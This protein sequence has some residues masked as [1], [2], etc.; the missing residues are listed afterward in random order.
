MAASA[1]PVPT[2]A[3]PSAQAASLPPGTASPATGP[4]LLDLLRASM[5]RFAHRPA[6]LI[7]PGFRTRT[8]THA[9]LA[10]LMPKVARVLHEM[11]L[12]KGD[13][14]VIWAVNRPE[15]GL[16]FLGALHAGI[17]LVPLDVRS[18][19]DFAAKIARRTRASAVLASV[20]TAG[21][22]QGLHLP[23][24]N[25]EAIPDLARDAEPLP[26][27]EVT[28]AD[29]VE[30][31][32]TSGTTGEPKGAMI[33][34]ANLAAN[35][36][37][38]GTVFPFQKDER[39]LSILPLSH[40]FEQTCGFL[41]PLLYGCSIV[42]PVS[43]QPAVLI[44]T[45]RDFRVTMLLVVPAG[46]KL[47]NNAI[48]RKVDAAGKRR[49]FERLHDLGARLPRPLK[50]L[51]FRSV[52]SQFGGR[53]RTLA[54]GAAA[55]E[56]DLARRWID[57]GFDVLQGYGATELSPVVAF[58]H[59]QRNRLGTVGQA[60]PGVELRIGPDGEVLARGP[61]VFA[62]YWED[63]DATAQ[64]ID[65]DG[66]YHT[67]DIGEL[68]GDGFLTLRGRKKD[69]LAMA[70]GT[71]VYP[72]DIEAV[73]ARDPRLRDATVVG[74][75]PPNA[76]LK[77]HAVLLLDDTSLADAVIRD[78][79]AQLG[80]HQQIRSHSL[81]PDDDFPRTHTLKVKKRD[82]LQRLETDAA[83]VAAAPIARSSAAAAPGA[84]S[85]GDALA[86]LVASVAGVPLADVQPSA[87][88]SRDLNMDSLSRVELLGV[89]EEEL[90]VYID[91]A[92]L[93]PDT[94]IG[95]LAAMAEQ[96]RDAKPERGI[97][98]WPLSPVAR[99]IG[100]G[101]QAL[102]MVPFF[103][104]A[105]RVRV[106]GREH[107]RGLRGPVLFTPNHH[108][109][110][111]VGI[112]LSHFPLG[113]RWRLST[114]AAADDIFGNP[115]RGYGAAL[116]GNAFPLAR[117]GAIRRSLELLGARLDRG[118]SILIFPEGKLTP[119]GPMQ[120]FKSG[121]G[122]IAVE[123]ATPVVPMKLKVERYSRLD[124]DIAAPDGQRA[125]RGQVEIVFG[126]PIHFPWGTDHDAATR[127]LEEAVAA[128]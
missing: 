121:T 108:L 110:N 40:L 105:Y 34:H 109:H 20:Q 65:G 12:R 39:L 87:C 9:D 99:A 120:P 122:L 60:I 15:W 81:W 5:A 18:Q 123:G 24:L 6:L 37:T 28:P 1:P 67:G 116:I 45:F 98:G 83:G 44:R 111:D 106:T 85:A 29:L 126:P 47:L 118:F 86:A 31:V 68:S 26:R 43:R 58:T 94:T 112:L 50:R 115:I 77:V 90:G 74:W 49:T 33:T 71:K 46:L 51:L 104:L 11:G 42:Y 76:E 59:P 103:T 84:A 10:Q 96:A 119:G 69:M 78:A 92:D 55:L 117:E 7:R 82:I 41:A 100:I 17:V 73:L 38:L 66:F 19:P 64:A 27:V 91:D 21:L 80:A 3:E 93:D 22:A 57:M 48:E 101:L 4:T 125:W 63:A 72:E 52:L 113:W 54:I 70:D 35:A 114:A 79:N 13:R 2:P 16:A 75:Q 8:W 95:Q 89:I 25:I 56:T 14:V 107:L 30:V 97:F 32:F 102:F 124:A 127:L 128:L 88:L 53:F 62:G 23:V 61:N 36:D